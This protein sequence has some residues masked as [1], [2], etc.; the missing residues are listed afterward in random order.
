MNVWLSGIAAWILVSYFISRITL[1]IKLQYKRQAA[2]DYLLIEVYTYKKI[3]LYSLQVPLLQITQGMLPWLETEVHSGEE[4]ITTH[5]ERE[6]RF[7]HK[8]VK[9]PDKFYD[10]VRIVQYYT[11]MYNQFMKNIMQSMQCE[12]LE[13]RTAYGLGDSAL[14]AFFYG[15]IWMLKGLLVTN[16]RERFHFRQPPEIR[17]APFFGEVQFRVD[18]RCIFSIKLGNLINAT[19]RMINERQGGGSGWPNIRSR[20]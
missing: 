10:S 11:R 17:V 20:G 7:V 9:D 16:L 4:K 19:L 15:I 13:W 1:Y 8:S 3:V 5:V 12:K 6:K 18:F 2:D 14:T